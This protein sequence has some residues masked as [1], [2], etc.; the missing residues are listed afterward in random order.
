MVCTPIIVTLA[1][2]GQEDSEF[3]VSLGYY[4]DPVSKHKRIKRRRRRRRK[5][6]SQREIFSY[7]YTWPQFIPE[8]PNLKDSLL[9]CDSCKALNRQKFER[10]DSLIL[11]VSFSLSTSF[12]FCLSVCLSV[13]LFLLPL[14]F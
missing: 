5:V 8:H 11:S 14:S 12:F 2:P 3:E 7:P 4:P 10:S 13:C 1:R 6:I 9:Q